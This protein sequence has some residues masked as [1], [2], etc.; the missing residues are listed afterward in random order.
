MRRLEQERVHEAE[1]GGVEANPERRNQDAPRRKRPRLHELT[2]GKPEVVQH[3]DMMRC[4]RH[5]DS[6]NCPF[7]SCSCSCSCSNCQEHTVVAPLCRG[8]SLSRT[9]RH[10]AVAT[11]PDDSRAARLPY[12]STT[13]TTPTTHP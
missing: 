7:S 13:T 8:A 12:N 1:N 11:V 4:G 5:L 3:T 10:S 2:K 6:T 9:R